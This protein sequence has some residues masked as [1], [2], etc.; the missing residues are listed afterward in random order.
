MDPIR[1][2]NIILCAMIVF[3]GVWGYLKN[4]DVFSMLIAAAFALFGV[5]HAIGIF[6]PMRFEKAILTVRLIAYIIVVFALYTTI[7]GSRK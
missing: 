5:S 4:K 7:S 1:M 2:L 6:N 3:L